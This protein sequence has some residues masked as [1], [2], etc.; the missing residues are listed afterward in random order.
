MTDTDL[1]KPDIARLRRVLAKIDAEPETW[2]QSRFAV[3][4]ECGTACCIAGHIVLDSGGKLDLPGYMVGQDSPFTDDGH[5]I[6]R[7]A[8]TL[9]GITDKESN[10]LF[11]GD[12]DRDDIQRICEDIAE[13]AGEKL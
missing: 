13:R 4:T 8:Q 9:V 12:N 7:L 11:D 10:S 3:K 1:P 6:S 2:D 5:S